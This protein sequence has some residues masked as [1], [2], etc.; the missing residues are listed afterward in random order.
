[1]VL[2]LGGLGG[3]LFWQQQT[4]VPSSTTP[5]PDLSEM[6]KPLTIDLE[7]PV[8]GEVL[9]GNELLVKGVTFPETTV[10]FYTETDE[11]S[12]ESDAEGNFEGTLTLES[13][14]N[15]L[16]VMAFT[17]KGEEQSFSVDVVYDQ[18]GAEETS[19]VMGVKIAKKESPPGQVKKQTQSGPAAVIGNVED[20]SDDSLTVEGK[21]NQEKIRTKIEKN[22]RIYGQDKKLLK[23]EAIQADDLAAVIATESGEA[24]QGAKIRKAIRVYVRT[25]AEVRQSK[26]RALHGVITSIQGGVITLVHQIHREWVYT[27]VYDESTLIKIKGV[28]TGS[29]TDLEVGQR[30]AAVGSLDEKGQLTAKRI[31]VIPGLA[32]GIFEKLPLDLTESEAT[33]PATPSATITATPSALLSPTLA[34]TATVTPSLTLTP[35]PNLTLTPTVSP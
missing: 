14:I 35:T 15:S 7:S 9:L 24:T 4:R 21:K 23:L 8:D 10:V 5:M 3:F 16:T 1:V 32:T 2:L 34:P 13:G 18:E 19:Q 31:H 6:E 33:G 17:E 29:A 28:E 30:I 11:N 22:T 26:R 27:L 25:A 20:V 12:V